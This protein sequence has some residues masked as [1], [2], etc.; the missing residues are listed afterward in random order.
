MLHTP[1]EA[2]DDRERQTCNAADFVADR[3]VG[4][5]NS[6]RPQETE[7]FMVEDAK[8]AEGGDQR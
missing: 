3:I 2:L 5:E 6:F 4:T 1:A 8:D 7:F